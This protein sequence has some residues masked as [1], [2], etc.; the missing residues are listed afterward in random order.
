MKITLE[1]DNDYEDGVSITTHVEADVPH[2]REQDYNDL[3]DE[4]QLQEWAGEN[5]EEHTGAGRFAG[6]EEGLTRTPDAL[7]TVKITACPDEPALVGK[8]FEFGL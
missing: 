6:N 4:D 2:P 5:L 8:E 7:Y 3:A 1:I